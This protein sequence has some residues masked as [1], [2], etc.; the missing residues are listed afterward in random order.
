M[1]MYSGNEVTARMKEL[2]REL[3]NA[4]RAYYQE[5]REVMSNKEYDAL[6]DELVRLE[7]ESGIVLAGSPT[8]K[9]GY[10]VVSALP[11]LRHAKPM[12]SLD[13]TKDPDALL[14]WLG[15]N[16]A[17]L[18]WKLDGLTV[19]LTYE[20]GELKQAATRGNGEIGEE[21]TANARTF[22]NLPL[23][24]PFAGHLVV[25]GEAILSY[26]QFERVNRELEADAQ[27]KNPRNLCSGSVRQLNSAVTAERGVDVIVYALVEIDGEGLDFGDSREKQW[28][29]VKRQ[30]F[31]LVDYERINK[32]NLKAEL[33]RFSERVES[34]PY[35]VDG[36]VLALDSLSLGEELGNTAKFPRHSIA[37]KWQDETAET[38]LLYIEWS[39]SRTGA[40][41][42]VAVFEPVELE[43]TTVQRASV[44]NVSVLEELKLGS[45]D[46]VRVY[47]A[48]MIIPQISE[49]LTPGELDP[50]PERCPRCGGETAVI[51]KESAKVLY[52]TN[53]ACPAKTLRSLEHFVSRPAMN[54]EGLSEMTLQRFMDEG[55]LENFV[56]LYRLGEHKQE[57]AE[58]D[59]F[60]EKSAEKILAAIDASRNTKLSRLLAAIGIPGVGPAGA[61]ALE[62][63]F[64]ADL[65]KLTAAS[66]EEIAAVEGFGSILADQV[67]DYFRN[68]ENRRLLDLL[69]KEL[70][71]EKEDVGEQK[72]SGLTFVIT[73]SLNRFENRDLLK[74]ELEKRGAKV[75]GSVSAIT[76]YLI[77]NDINSGSSKNK[78][79]RELGIE[80]I[81][82]ETMIAR[83]L[84]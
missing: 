47:K 36:L 72:L 74:E 20:G 62:A 55:W 37:F 17:L 81:D 21:I 11:K 40:I 58:L 4:S 24:I 30:G 61:K 25:R 22:R 38:R 60:G 39:P 82:E 71:L 26:E 3:N 48:N 59:G 50:I 56:D 52:C 41:N 18:S 43:G 27:Y 73:G 75:A 51:M 57:I 79:A 1:D 9:V 54:I 29:F 80:I 16:D 83:F 31:T 70:T 15:D 66:P 77:N 35:P 63:A 10:E 65:E 6:Y 42:P 13:K 78:K 53:P 23:R 5:A 32:T 69:L 76:S 34:F 44:H 84:Q 68:E 8:Q 7:K 2:A 46:K 64:Q 33:K 12:M 49:N 45:G 28:Q 19:V 67:H 14:E